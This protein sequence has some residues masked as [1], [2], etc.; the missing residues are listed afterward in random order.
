MALGG[1][2]FTSFNKKLPGAYHN[3]VSVAK[4]NVTLG[5]RGYV[6]MPLAMDW[7]VDGEVFTVTSSDFYKKSRSIF[8]YEYSD[9]K[10]KGLRDLFMHAHTVYFYKLGTSAV[11]AANDFGEA[12]YCGVRGNALSIVIKSV[13]DTQYEVSTLLD[14]VIV[15]TQVVDGASEL[16]D[17]DFVVFDKEALLA[18]TAK[19]PMTG[20]S[21]GTI[22]DS[23]WQEALTAFEAYNF[24]IIGVVSTED[25]VKNLVV[26]WTKTMREDIGA[27]FQVV[28]YSYA[29][30][31]EGVINFATSPC[32]E[33][34]DEADLVYWVSGK[35]A[36][37]GVNESCTN[38]IYDGE[39]T[40][41]PKLSQAE[42]ANAIDDGKLVMHRVG[43]DIRI[44]KDI[45]SL[46]TTTVTKGNEFKKNQT[47]RVI[48]E[49]AMGD[50]TV[51][52][53][54]FLGKVPNDSAG[55]ISLWNALVKRRQA[56]Q[57]MRAIEGYLPEHTV[58]NAGDTKESVVVDDEI[59]VVNAMEQ[60]YTTT[61]VA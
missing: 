53:T 35:E 18:E 56:L 4:A 30:D 21:N 28:V 15:E 27:K 10:L 51:F 54:Q 22:N 39:Y 49:I 44:L 58:V 16:I 1:G 5:E 50:A 59:T 24:N 2:E 42:L 40:V 38:A 41:K 20:G 17:N 61:T 47:I 33:G 48:D 14:D 52:N 9:D 19:T 13:N 45:N 25:E 36:S 3:F 60:V 55:R 37:C 34:E 23:A 32:G 57:D 26:Q 7:G 12:K 11:K 8:G 31:H 43:D 46:V 29:G 6:A